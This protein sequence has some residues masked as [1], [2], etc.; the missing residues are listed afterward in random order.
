MKAVSN[1]LNEE[2]LE[3]AV[4]VMTV[5]DAWKKLN[6]IIEENTSKC[7]EA[8]K[9]RPWIAHEAEVQR[10]RRVKNKAWKKFM[11]L[12]EETKYRLDCENATRLE[13]LKLKYCFT[14]NYYQMYRKLKESLGSN[15]KLHI[16][17]QISCSK[18]HN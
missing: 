11:K 8:N 18:S 6:E 15:K 14:Q 4:M 5:N 9:Q 7:K 1:R 16:E 2:D 17:A 12:K 10:K 13:N 3:N